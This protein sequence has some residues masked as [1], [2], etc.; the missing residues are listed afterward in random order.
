MVACGDE[1]GDKPI[2]ELTLPTSASTT[3]T[4]TTTSP[5]DPACDESTQPIELDT[6]TPGAII[7]T[8]DAYPAN[9]LFYCFV[10]TEAGLTLTVSLTGLTS[11]ADLHL[12]YGTLEDLRTRA[13]WSSILGGMNDDVVVIPDAEAGIYYIEV[14]DFERSGTPFTLEVAAGDA[15]AAGD[16]DPPAQ[17]VELDT[18]MIG[19][20]EAT[21]DEYP[22]NAL[23]FCVEV[24]SGTTVLYF[25]LAGLD[26]D[27]DI[28]IGFGS[29]DT[30]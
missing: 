7:A 16:C 27:L 21:A 28:Y 2:G 29:I 20:L 13:D 25:T 1:G 15:V 26:T 23:Y 6:P 30:V 19:Y 11:D 4:P 18:P 9:A 24:P 5:S 22:A 17:P 3:T 10:M 14:V 8:V 12:A